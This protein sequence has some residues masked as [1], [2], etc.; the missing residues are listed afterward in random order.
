MTLCEECYLKYLQNNEIGG[1][2]SLRDNGKAKFLG[3]GLLMPSGLSFKKDKAK[4]NTFSFNQFPSLSKPTIH[5]KSESV[6][7]DKRVER[8]S[9]M[10]FTDS[11]AKDRYKDYYI[12]RT[13]SNLEKLKEE[14]E[15]SKFLNHLNSQEEEPEN[16]S[17]RKPRKLMFS[18]SITKFYEDTS[19][20]N[21]SKVFSPHIPVKKSEFGSKNKSTFIESFALSNINDLQTHS[22]TKELSE[23]SK[24]KFSIDKKALFLKS[25]RTCKEG[26]K[27]S[28]KAYYGNKG[29]LNEILRIYKSS[30]NH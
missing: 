25:N 18:K 2:Y 28:A 15:A 13:F 9:S 4:R 6:L 19:N 26:V 23:D 7:D 1:G 5:K 16:E 12:R 3:T 24:E 20:L 21:H 30:K 10:F 22:A 17:Y 14:K 29:K 27:P 8:I 11:E